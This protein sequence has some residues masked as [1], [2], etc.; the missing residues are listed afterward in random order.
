MMDSAE[1]SRWVILAVMWVSGVMVGI[2][3]R[4]MLGC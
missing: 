3:A 1:H 4:G 2:A